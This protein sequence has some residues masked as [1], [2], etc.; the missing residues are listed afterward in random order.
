L[1]YQ[2]KFILEHYKSFL[3][4]KLITV[5]IASILPFL[6]KIPIKIKQ[7]KTKDTKINQN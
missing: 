7:N 5:P 4:R 6:P 3:E 1:C 2:K